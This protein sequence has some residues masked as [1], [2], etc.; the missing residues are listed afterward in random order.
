MQPAAKQDVIDRYQAR[1]RKFGYSPQTLGWG[2][3][4][5][6]EVRFGVL[7]SCAL[8]LPESSVLD[9][10]CGFADLYGF[11]ISNGWHGRYTGID[12]VP[13]LLE[14]ARAQHPD[15]DLREVDIT[16]PIEGLPKHDFVIASGVF[17]ALL[18]EG[19]NPEHIRRALG[20]MRDLSQIAVCAD[21][22]TSYVD[23]REPGLWYT[24]PCWAL[25]VAKQLS[26]RVTVRH[27]YMP[28]EFCLFVFAD[29]KFT[30]Q[31][32]FGSLG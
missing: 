20:A 14:V 3:D 27:D 5:R 24:D 13:G 32:V 12:I 7:A 11:L 15:L 25:D 31:R 1:L 17:N 23:F 10:G 28:F 29:D 21:F 4:G 26:R 22:L 2:K 9:V 8:A 6:Q 30:S 16:G 18:A 19:D